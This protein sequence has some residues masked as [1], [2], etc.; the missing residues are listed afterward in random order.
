[1][2]NVLAGPDNVR[3]MTFPVTVRIVRQGSFHGIT[4]LKSVVLNDGLGVLG[5]DECRSDGA[6]FPGAFEGSGL[7]RVQLPSTL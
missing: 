4:S 5:T 1:M 6:R 7:K 2:D 3:T